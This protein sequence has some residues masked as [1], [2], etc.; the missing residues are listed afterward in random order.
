[1]SSATTAAQTKQ[2]PT[3][4]PFAYQFLA[5]AIAGVSEVAGMY[6]LDLVKTR[7]QLQTTSIRPRGTSSFTH[8]GKSI[9]EA[10]PYTS[11]LDC[12]RKVVQQEGLLNLY[13][14]ALP[15]L[16]AEAPRRAIKFGAN[17]QWGL[18]LKKLFSLDQFTAT[19]AGFVGSL[20]GAT[21]AFLVTPFD[22]L[23]VRLQDR[24]SLGMYKGTLDCARKIGAQ[25]G[26]LTF[27]H[28]FESTVWRHASWSGVY[29]MTIHLFRIAL[30]QRS[31]TSKNE[32]MLRNFVA[33]TIG[34]ILG[35]LVNTPFDVVK[36]RIQNQRKDN[37]RYGFALPS[38]AR[39]YREEGFRALYKGLAPKLVRLGPGGGLL[40][41]VFDRVSELIRGQVAGDSSSA[42]TPIE[43][44]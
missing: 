4:L 35:T 31:S 26:L 1:M 28:G 22:L 3:P 10:A 41:V 42:P 36:S 17:E 33:G 8:A 9:V 18:A 23:K 34:G 38:V 5:G 20:A 40:L 21:E 32:R 37:V 43:S 30:P 44:S 27:Y 7:L 15:P 39:I 12:L 11:I 29:F 14:G 24:H 6:P 2:K 16:L 25:E 19:Q 13:R